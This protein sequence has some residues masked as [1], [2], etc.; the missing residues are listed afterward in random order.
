MQ[1]SPIFPISSGPNLILIFCI[2][3]HWQ[4][5]RC[6]KYA[7]FSFFFSEKAVKILWIQERRSQRKLISHISLPYL[8]AQ[9][10]AN[11]EI[12]VVAPSLCMYVFDSDWG[13]DLGADPHFQRLS[14][15]SFYNPFHIISCDILYL[16]F[17]IES[18]LY[19]KHRQTGYY[20]MVAV[21]N[22]PKIVWRSNCINHEF[23]SCHIVPAYLTICGRCARGQLI[24]W[25]QRSRTRSPNGSLNR[26][27]THGHVSI[28]QWLTRSGRALTLSS[29]HPRQQWYGN[30]S[31][32]LIVRW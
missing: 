12:A 3:I 13:A 15:Y 23:K 27:T 8:Y 30:P 31:I 2:P 16:C 11:T 6:H 21:T 32:K 1:V 17:L 28:L 26:R 24:D 25:E 7:L 9:N 19:F 5:T 29:L 10:H 14:S 20:L 22:S 18:V 4:L